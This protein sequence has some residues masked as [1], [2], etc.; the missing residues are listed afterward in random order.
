V[1]REKRLDRC[2]ERVRILDEREVILTADHDELG[3]GIASAMKR[4][5]SMGIGSSSP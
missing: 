2:R 3:P 4:E 1:L 5:D